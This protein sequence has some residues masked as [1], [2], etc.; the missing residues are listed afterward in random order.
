MTAF[1][2]IVG[3]RNEAIIATMDLLGIAGGIER[4]RTL[5]KVK[6]LANALFKETHNDE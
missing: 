3:I 6:A 1:G 5:V 2:A 4:E